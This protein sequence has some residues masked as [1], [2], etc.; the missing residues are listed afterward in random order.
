MNHELERTLQDSRGE[1][2][3][4]NRAD[5]VFFNW[6]IENCDY[7]VVLAALPEELKII[8]KM[9]PCLDEKILLQKKVLVQ[10]LFFEVAGDYQ[11]LIAVFRVKTDNSMAYLTQ[12][13][14]E[15]EGL[16]EFRKQYDALYDQHYTPLHSRGILQ[17]QSAVN[18]GRH[19]RKHVTAL[20]RP[21][22]N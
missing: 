12:N 15:T 17:Q 19:T 8:D 22:A 5:P 11:K 10:V 3:L 20:K 18:K 4:K 2:L 9:P 6:L 13:L 1:E 21:Q 14:L 7:P 16:D